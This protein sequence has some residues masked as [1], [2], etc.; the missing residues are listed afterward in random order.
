MPQLPP[1]ELDALAEYTYDHSH[2]HSTQ[3]IPPAT[4]PTPHLLQPDQ[5][6]LC[7]P[8]ITT[9]TGN[10]AYL[11][12]PHAPPSSPG[13]AR[14]SATNAPRSWPLAANDSA[15]PSPPEPSSLCPPPPAALPD[16]HRPPENITQGTAPPPRRGGPTCWRPCFSTRRQRVTGY[17]LTALPTGAAS[18]PPSALAECTGMQ[19]RSPGTAQGLAR[20]THTQWS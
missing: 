8:N 5:S 20:D 13:M 15:P 14:C 7:A 9:P 1:L 12:S 6:I 17:I 2:H 18:G 16:H 11:R 3:P 4:P 10:S 19:V